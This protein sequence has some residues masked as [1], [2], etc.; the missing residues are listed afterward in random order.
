MLA[1]P[2][3]E[4][5]LASWSPPYLVQPK[6]NGERCRSIVTQDRCLLLSSSEEIISSVPHINEQMLSLPPGEYDGELYTHG[7]TWSDIHSRVSRTQ[8]LHPDYKSI[9]YYIFDTINTSLTQVERYKYFIDIVNRGNLWSLNDILIV[10]SYFA[11][12]HQELINLYE[13][14]ISQGYEGFIVREL[15][16]P[17]E[18]KRSKGMM[19]FKPKATDHY[20]ITAPIEAVSEDGLPL[21][22]VGAFLCRDDM[23]TAFK[24]GAGKLTHDKA[25][26]LWEHRFDIMDGAHYLEVEYQTMSDKNKVPLFSRAVRVLTEEEYQPIK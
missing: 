7:L 11:K 5:R 18:R 24:V 16:S 1:H 25:T 14:F 26:F 20:R 15:F 9:N 13:E 8:N 2:Y 10:P 21:G 3:S 12:T 6:L 23:N 4:K 22:R 17:Y 19:K